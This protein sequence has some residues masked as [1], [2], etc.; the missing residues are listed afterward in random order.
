MQEAW[1]GIAIMKLVEKYLEAIH[2]FRKAK[3][4]A[5]RRKRG[6][7]VG[8]AAADQIGNLASAV[9]ATKSRH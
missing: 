2:S 6:V 1:F 8:L 3:W 5:L 4:R 9:E 7:L